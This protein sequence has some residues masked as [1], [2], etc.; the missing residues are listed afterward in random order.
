ML[1]TCFILKVIFICFVKIFIRFFDLLDLVLYIK[2]L[3][4]LDGSDLVVPYLLGPP[5]VC[6]TIL[7]VVLR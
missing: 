2:D 7:D 3:H 6:W 5:L 1:R 4:M